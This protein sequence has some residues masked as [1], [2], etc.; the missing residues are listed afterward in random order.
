MK[1]KTEFCLALYSSL[2]ASLLKS[3]QILLLIILLSNN[4]TFSQEIVPFGLE[5]IN[6]NDIKFYG[7]YLFAAT[8]S[9]VYKRYIESFG[10]EWMHIG[11]ENK[12]VNVVYPHDLGPVSWTVSA[13]ISPTFTPDDSALIYC[14]CDGDWAIADSGINRSEITSINSMDGFPSPAIC[15]ETFAGGNGKLY[16]RGFN[17]WY[18]EIFNVGGF[19]QLNVIRTDFRNGNIWIGGETGFFQPFIAKSMDLGDTWN[20][21]YP[22]LGGDNAC[23]SIEFDLND[24]NVVYAGMEGLVLKTTDGGV[25]WNSTGLSNTPYYFFGLA[26]DTISNVLYAGGSTNTNEFGLYY[27]IDSGLTWTEIQ[28]QV[29]YKGISSIVFAPTPISD[30]YTLYL[31]TF[32]DGVLWIQPLLPGVDDENNLPKDFALFQNY[33]NPFNPITNIGFRIAEFGFVS[34]KVYDVLGR[35]VATLVNEEKFPGVYEVEFNASQLSSGIYFYK[36]QTEAY[37]L[38]KKMIYLK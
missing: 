1:T 34:L 14:Y 19:Y 36:L 37:S 38:T 25:T 9:G 30:V 5:G 18:E 13:G 32:G 26:F 16:R 11:L 28:T 31:S 35:E 33:P 29:S 24:T 12:K 6:V 20:I 3:Y 2:K 17:S 27:S 22:D 23:N 7:D 8:D 21:S 4:F 10:Y 15:G